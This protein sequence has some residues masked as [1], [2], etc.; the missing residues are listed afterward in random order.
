MVVDSLLVFHSSDHASYNMKSH[1]SFL[2]KGLSPKIRGYVRH[3]QDG[4]TV[5]PKFVDL[6]YKDSAPSASKLHASKSDASWR[7]SSSNNLTLGRD[8]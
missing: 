8:R 6:L 2:R 7:N 4:Y 1:R 3:Q 5:T